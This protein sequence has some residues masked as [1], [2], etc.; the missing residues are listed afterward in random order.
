[1]NAV[2]IGLVDKKA[3]TSADVDVLIECTLASLREQDISLPKISM[4]VV[5]AVKLRRNRGAAVSWRGIE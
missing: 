4:P 1:M 5:P 3:V 2:P